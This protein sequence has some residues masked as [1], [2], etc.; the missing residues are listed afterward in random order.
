MASSPASTPA[1]LA[2]AGTAVV[3]TVVD[4]TIPHDSAQSHS[5]PASSATPTKTV[6]AVPS[7]SPLLP[8]P[9]RLVTA[10]SAA[11][12]SPNLATVTTAPADRHLL[13]DPVDRPP[14]TVSTLHL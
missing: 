9:V 4:A 14:H 3:A 6:R 2:V 10:V 5:P 12:P 8:T 11:M 7:V 1:M 13:S